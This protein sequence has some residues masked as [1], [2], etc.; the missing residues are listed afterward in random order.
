MG[1][2]GLGFR[3]I[4]FW[5]QLDTGLSLRM[6]TGILFLKLFLKALSKDASKKGAE[7]VQVS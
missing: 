6:L 5:V 1:V 2:E 3:A 7:G 4:G